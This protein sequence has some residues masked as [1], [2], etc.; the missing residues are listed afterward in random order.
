MTPRRLLVPV[1]G[2]PPPAGPEA[3]VP[4][5]LKVGAGEHTVGVEGCRATQG[6]LQSLDRSWGVSSLVC[7]D[8]HLSRAVVSV[9]LSHH[10]LGW[11]ESWCQGGEA[12]GMGEPTGVGSVPSPPIP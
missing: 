12:G 9:S 1:E 8:H 7:C 10:F 4:R 11:L 3:G 2:P 5:E 6:V